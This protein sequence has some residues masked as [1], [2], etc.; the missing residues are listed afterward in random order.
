MAKLTATKL[1]KELHGLDHAD[2]ARRVGQ[3]GNSLAADEL[4][5]FC[6]ELI[7]G[8]KYG[9]FGAQ[10]AVALA[11][12]GNVTDV[13][14][15]ALAHP[16]VLVQRHAMRSVHHLALTDDQIG[17]A[18][19]G[20]APVHRP[21]CIALLRNGQRFE[22]AHR[23]VSLTT[24]T[25][26]AKSQLLTAC[27]E[28]TAREVLP[29]VAHAV[30][31]WSGLAR[32]HPDVLLSFA[33]SEISA[34][35]ASQQLANLRRFSSAFG[36]LALLRPEG[37]L[38]L[39]GSVADDPGFLLATELSHLIRVAPRQAATY[40]LGLH[41]PTYIII[42]RRIGRCLRLVENEP[43]GASPGPVMRALA[44]RVGDNHSTLAELLRSA[45]PS[46]RGALLEEAFSERSIDAV[47]L[48][49]ALMEILPT[50]VRTQQARRMLMLREVTADPA[51]TFRISSY[52]PFV[53]AWPLLEAMTKRSD[54]DQ[55]ANGYQRMIVCATLSRDPAAFTQTMQHLTRLK[56]DQDPVRMQA[57]S[58]LRKIPAVR[59]RDEDAPALASL[60]ECIV[61]ARDTSWSTRSN[62]QSVLVE[63]LLT[64]AMRPT[65]ILFQSAL[66]SLVRLAGRDGTL[67]LPPLAERLQ[68]RHVGAF[69]DALLPLAKTR[70]LTDHEGLTI[71]IAR[72]LGRRGWNHLGLQSLLESIVFKGTVSGATSAAELYLANPRFRVA[73]AK[74]LV[75]KDPSYLHIAAVSQVANREAQHL[76]NP[77]LTGKAL[78]GRFASKR[79]VATVPLFYGSF[80]RWSP[81]QVE[82]YG[83]LLVRLANTKGATA[84][85]QVGAIRTITQ[86][87]EIASTLINAEV[88]N[89][90]AD[91]PRLEAAIAGLANTDRPQSS[92]GTLVSFAATD[93]ARVAIYALGRAARRSRAVDSAPL[94][95]QLAK[96][97]KTKITSRKEAIRLLGELRSADVD[98]AL[99]TLTAEPELHKDLRIALGWSALANGGAPWFLLVMQSLSTGSLDEQQALLDLHPL[100]VPADRRALVAQ[101]VVSLTQSTDPTIRKCAYQSLAAWRQWSSAVTAIGVEAFTN[102]DEQ[103]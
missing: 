33:Q 30:S 26:R 92:I 84:W 75:S 17:A 46:Q 32:A 39:V 71:S 58:T 47:V 3:L 89:Q 9:D 95:I 6:A 91:V 4:H 72:C 40:I 66:T 96:D 43:S 41:D 74:A 82:A 65:G 15:E 76:L 67:P 87:P 80:Q 10:T 34:A 69:V 99:A 70:A 7:E 101:E 81:A 19:L 100:R 59:F 90:P 85:E 13:V 22:L 1:V 103:Q 68:E 88:T 63:V 14:L 86:L 93:R 35:P 20:S 64:S 51:I 2:R 57:T 24:Q 48:D 98:G 21:I 8:S 38:A 27:D 12:H 45:P 62:L 44:R 83:G 16:S 49:D 79:N 11:R 37:L 77:L 73:R 36:A 55:R 102:L 31:S 23:L 25:D 52:L 28:A 42:N 29:S 54:A 5:A 18:Y 97:A 94:L 78:K 53:E 60:T 56:N 50:T 61:D